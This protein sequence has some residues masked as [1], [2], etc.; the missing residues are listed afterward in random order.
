MNQY[1]VNNIP[2]LH[3]EVK[4][5]FNEVLE[6]QSLAVSKH[7][8]YAALPTEHDIPICVET[9]GYLCMINQALCPAEGIEWCTLALFTENHDHINKHCLLYSKEDIL[10]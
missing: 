10:T 4:L 6:G 3:K 9:Q 7:G 8:T 2:A 1:K 5:Q